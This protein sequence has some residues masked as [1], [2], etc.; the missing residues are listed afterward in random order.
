MANHVFISNFKKS[1]HSFNTLTEALE[2]HMAEATN[3]GSERTVAEWEATIDAQNNFTET[4]ILTSNGSAVTP[5]TAGNGYSLTRTWSTAKLDA[6]EA[7]SP[8]EVTDHGP[9]W[10]AE[11]TGGR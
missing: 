7:G 9:G 1:G 8:T 4:K 11:Y 3:R 6:F 5:G 2:T 10:T